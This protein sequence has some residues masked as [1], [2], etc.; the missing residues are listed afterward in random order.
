MRKYIGAISSAL[1]G[2][3]TFVFLSLP[4]MS[5]EYSAF[6]LTSD[7][8]NLSGWDLLKKSWEVDGFTLYKVFTIIAIVVAC[9][10]IIS[11][12]IMILRNLKVLKFKFSMNLINNILLILFLVCAIVAF[13]GLVQMCGS[14]GALGVEVSTTPAVGAYLLLGFA[15][16][17]TLV[18]LLFS[19][20]AK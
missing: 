11:A 12:V 1:M 17:L 13:V 9:L 5:T 10:L 14:A 7:P 4:T 8:Q 19:K 20:K 2:I 15:V 16:V 6:G 18:S 3:L